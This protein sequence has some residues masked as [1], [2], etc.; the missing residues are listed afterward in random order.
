MRE[1]SQAVSS[2]KRSHQIQTVDLNEKQ[3]LHT[4][5]DTFTGRVLHSF[6][7]TSDVRIHFN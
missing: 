5:I 1:L 3:Q 4:L 6:Q 7:L 2:E